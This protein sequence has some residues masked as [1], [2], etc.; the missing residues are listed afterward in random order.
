MVQA[1]NTIE[2]NVQAWRDEPND[3]RFAYTDES[4]EG[5]PGGTHRMQPR[6]IHMFLKLGLNLRNV[7]A[8]NVVFV[9]SKDEAALEKVKDELLRVSWPVHEVVLGSLGV[10]CVL[11]LGTTAGRW[12]RQKLGAHE[13][14]A[15]FVEDNAREWRSTAHRTEDGRIVVTV[16]HPGRADRR[17][18]A[19]DPSE[20]V[21]SALRGTR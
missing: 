18:P 6:M 14:I 3:H 17:N 15:E 5:R 4:W 2:R 1:E 16:K 19:A 9:R 7:P 10:R 8:A 20:R 12:V 11:A 13:L 21:R